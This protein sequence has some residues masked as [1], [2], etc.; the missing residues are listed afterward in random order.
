MQISVSLNISESKETQLSEILGCSKASLPQ[1]L[2][3]YGLAALQ[4]YIDMFLGEKAFSRGSD[5]LE[6]RLYLLIEKVFDNEIPNE[7]KVSRLFQKTTSGS[8][9]LIRSVI[10]KYQYRLKSALEHSIK[11][12]VQKVSERYKDKGKYEAEINNLNIVDG[13]NQVLADLDGRI[14]K[15]KCKPE[16]GCVYEFTKAAYEK[17]CTKFEIEPASRS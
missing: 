2:A 10:S 11:V 7:A 13:I 6:H 14:P 17:L 15:I 3:S 8:R 9:S 1:M 12:V 4:E 16:T 5:I